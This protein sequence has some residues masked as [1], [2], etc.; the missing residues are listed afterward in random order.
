M[1]SRYR[2][3]CPILGCTPS[4]KTYRQMSLS[5]GVTP[6]R[7]DEV[8]DTEELFAEAIHRVVENKNL[9]GGDIAVITAGVP[10]GMSGTTN[11]IRVAT[12]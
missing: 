11:L 3:K 8:T 10:L 2:P 6:L 12:I 4:E 9:S 7:I 1:I 5:W